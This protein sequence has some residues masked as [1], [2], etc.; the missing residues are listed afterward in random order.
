MKRYQYGWILLFTAAALS[1]MACGLLSGI[2]DKAQQVENAAGTAKALATA[3]QEIVTQV[4]GSGVMQTALAYATQAE[5]SGLMETAQAAIATLPGQSADIKATAEAVI[6]Q[7]AYGQAPADIPLFPGEIGAF[8]GSSSLVTYTAPT[9]VQS[10]VDFYRQQ[11]PVYGWAS[12]GETTVITSSYA[13][14]SYQNASR[15]VTITISA[16][17]LT[18]E[19]LVVI[20]VFSN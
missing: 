2:A 14:L 16:T 1:V 18:S 10:I 6:T 20:S 4:S 7:G 12:G 11:M 5:E 9:D 19:S 13:V 8:F 15:R 17:P 3:G